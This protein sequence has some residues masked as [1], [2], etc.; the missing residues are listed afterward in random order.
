MK[1]ALAGIKG[2]FVYEHSYYGSQVR[3]WVWVA[4][5][6]TV[7][8]LVI[9]GG[10]YVI[11]SA[12]RSAGAASCRTFASQSGYHS[13]YKIQHSGRWWG[14]LRHVAE[15]TRAASEDGRRLLEGEQVAP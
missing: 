11:I 6:T 4:L 12:V 15:R 9:F 14:V 1:P 5:W 8:A 13:H 3:A 2:A 10:V 7:A